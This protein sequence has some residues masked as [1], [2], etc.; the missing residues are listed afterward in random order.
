MNTADLK[1]NQ[2]SG[3]LD[4]IRQ[5][6]ELP[7]L[8]AAVRIGNETTWQDACGWAD[9]EA[10]RP[11]TGEMVYPLGSISK[12]FIA[13]ML[14]QLVERG[15]V[16]L[17]DALVK[18]LPEYQV[19]S[20]FGET[21]PTSLRQLSAHTSG[22]PRDAAINFPM[23][24][25][26]AAWEFSAGQTALHWYASAEQVLASLA[27]VQLELPPDTAKH[28]SNLGIML[29]GIA[30]ER[31]CGQDFRSYVHENIFVPLG[32]ASAGFLDEPGAW[33]ERFPTGYGRSPDGSGSF[34]APRWQLGGAIY[35]GGIYATAADLARFC[36]AFLPGQDYAHVLRPDSIQRMI[37]PGA[38]GDTNL[39]WWKGWQ[40]GYANFGHA[41]AHVGFSSTALFVPE[42]KL[43]VAV[44]TNRWNPVVDTQDSTEVARELLTRMIPAAQ[45]SLPVF[46]PA[47]VDLARYAG[48]YRLPGSAASA[49]VSIQGRE[50]R[51]SVSGEISETLSLAAV[52]PHQFGPPGT[53]FPAVTFH[54]NA[55]GSITGLSYAL[56]AFQRALA[57]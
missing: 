26:L 24:Q 48:H 10:A 54:E 32:M 43:V 50:L 23:N 45:S 15:V 2:L 14:M 53:Q 57:D 13:T 40:A 44:Q 29:L 28:Y 19:I 42:L 11:A 47:A 4:T 35:T 52:G 55:Q 5:Q 17:E 27:Q 21:P 6:R 25:S 20:P 49:E 41:G 18:F 38:M 33:D 30:L 7:S 12:V 9:L 51:F 46:D 36:A 37:H 3:W 34:P 31:A 16:H 56:F 39:G 1:T 8:S 22:L